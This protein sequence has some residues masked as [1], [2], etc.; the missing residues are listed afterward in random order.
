MEGLTD[1]DKEKCIS[2]ITDHSK[3]GKGV[4]LERP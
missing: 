3:E 4:G 2:Q 1:L